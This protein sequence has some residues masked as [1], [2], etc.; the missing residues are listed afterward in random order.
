M[1][2]VT[3]AALPIAIL[4][5]RTSESRR[6]KIFNYR[7]RLMNTLS[8]AGGSVIYNMNN[9]IDFNKRSGFPLKKN[10]R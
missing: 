2:T 8:A 7:P 4:A 6:I 5:R 3:T 9:P 10:Q 1:Q